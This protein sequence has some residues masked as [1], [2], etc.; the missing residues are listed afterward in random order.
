M[1][2][3]VFKKKVE[4]RGICD[5]SY[6]AEIALDGKHSNIKVD[7]LKDNF[8][9]SFWWIESYSKKRKNK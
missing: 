9:Q 7:I 3:G 1:K 5:D 2:W 8:N 6:I 4:Q